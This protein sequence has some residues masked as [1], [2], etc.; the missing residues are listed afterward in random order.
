MRLK[1]FV[2]C[3][4]HSVSKAERSPFPSA[5]EVFE[6]LPSPQGALSSRDAMQEILVTFDIFVADY[7]GDSGGV[8]GDRPGSGG[9]TVER[10]R[11]ACRRYN[12]GLS[13]LEAVAMVKEAD[14]DGSGAVSREEY[15]NI[16]KNTGWF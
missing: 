5:V 12:V 3:C 14:R 7:S 8:G 2:A 6:G 15:V 1:C 11:R 10:L 4:V 16:M 9:I 13:D